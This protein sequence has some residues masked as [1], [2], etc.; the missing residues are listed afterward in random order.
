MVN[1]SLEVN[2]VS[3]AVMLTS[4]PSALFKKVNGYSTF[5]GV[6]LKTKHDKLYAPVFVLHPFLNF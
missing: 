1:F 4:L 3:K 5:A 2:R 6:T